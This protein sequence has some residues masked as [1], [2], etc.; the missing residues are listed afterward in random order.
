MKHET[1]NHVESN[2]IRRRI[3]SMRQAAELL[4]LSVPHLRRLVRNGSI[5]TP[6]KIGTRKLGWQAGVLFDFV[7]AKVSSSVTGGRNA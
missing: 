6:I 7:E 3:L 4:G 2:L 1:F 5:P